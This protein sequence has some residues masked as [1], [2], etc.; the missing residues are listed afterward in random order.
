MGIFFLT[1]WFLLGEGESSAQEFGCKLSK[2]KP[3]YCSIQESNMDS[4][5]I[6]HLVKLVNHLS[7]I[8]GRTILDWYL[9]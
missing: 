9:S 6:C 3:R 5:E 2:V 4:P 8:G 7:P 1:L